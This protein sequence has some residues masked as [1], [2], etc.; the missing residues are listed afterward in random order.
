[1]KVRHGGNV[2]RRDG[3]AEW[4]SSVTRFE[5]CRHLRQDPFLTLRPEAVCTF[6]RPAV[7]DL[8]PPR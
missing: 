4:L 5:V 1:M 2:D 8:N 7:L 3:E 6:A